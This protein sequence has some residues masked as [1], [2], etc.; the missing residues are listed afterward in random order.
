M[1]SIERKAAFSIAVLVALRMYG[2]FLII[3]V[4]SVYAKNIAGASDFLIGFAIGA[5]GLSQACLQIPMGFLSDIIGRRK[6]IAIGLCV[7]IL[8]SIIAALAESIFTIIVGRIIQ[9]AGAI[10][11]T[12]M[13]LIADIS[14]EDQRSKAMAVV[15]SSIGMAFIL[16]FITGPILAGY[17]GLSGLFWFTAGLSLLALLQLIFF[18]DEPARKRNQSY[19]FSEWWYI[20]RR[21][22]LLSLDVAIFLLHA[23]FTALF[24]ILPVILVE[25]LGLP[26]ESH[27]Q[28][29]LPV[30]LLSLFIMIPMII[31][32]EKLGKQREF[33]T[34][35]FLGLALSTLAFVMDF[36]NLWL[37][38]LVLVMYFGF[39][40]F[41]EASMP[42]LLSRLSG[43]KYRGAA[44]GMFSSFEFIGI[45]VGGLFAG[46]SIQFGN[47]QLFM[48]LA[49]GLILISLIVLFSLP[50]QIKCRV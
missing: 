12:G 39:F 50:K 43:D 16:A 3:P 13:A 47:S 11:S 9:G 34:L 1:N 7:F 15:G 5:Y 37:I 10:A 19:S 26:S 30:L 46:W 14:R 49:S 6:V 18:V 17:W 2:L 45:F 24:V 20:V 32:H 48:I 25:K 36:D 38:G 23:C 29:Y 33:I 28:L 40:N 41:L 42:A 21:R 22:E 44:M 27:W 31:L 35:A 8:G 4:F